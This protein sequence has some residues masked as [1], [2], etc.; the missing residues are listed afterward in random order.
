MRD[1]TQVI[2]HSSASFVKAPVEL[3]F[4]LSP[5]IERRAASEGLLLRPSALLR[6]GFSTPSIELPAESIFR[7]RRSREA[8]ATTRGIN[9]GNRKVDNCR[10]GRA[11]NLGKE[12]KEG[13]QVEEAPFESLSVS[14][15]AFDNAMRGTPLRD[16]GLSRG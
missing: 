16:V 14:R 4:S 12:G 10:H 3:R 8:M 11:A 15:L 2:E 13:S 6:T 1:A 5:G 7:R 9:T